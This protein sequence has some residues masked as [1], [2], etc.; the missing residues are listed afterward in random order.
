[1]I[2]RETIH[3]ACARSSTRARTITNTM[4]PVTMACSAIRSPRKTG[5]SGA[6]DG[7][8]EPSLVRLA[9][10]LRRFADLSNFRTTLCRASLHTVGIVTTSDAET[11]ASRPRLTSAPPRWLRILIPLV[12]MLVWLGV[13]AAGGSSFSRINEV[14]TNDQAQHLPASAEATSVQELQ[15]KFRD[16]D[17]VPAVLVYERATGLTDADKREIERQANRIASVRG[18]EADAV[19]P[20]I[21]SEDGQAA[22]VFVPMDSNIK[23]ADTVADV[24]DLLTA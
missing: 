11:S 6:R 18:V 9:Q 3:G 16:S 21:F 15:A 2:A 4:S 8:M 23:V 13:F 14:A 5:V 1:M 17:L 19:S 20:T 22:E 24:R 10:H 7:V 12:L